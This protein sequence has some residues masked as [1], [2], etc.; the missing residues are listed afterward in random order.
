MVEETTSEL[1]KLC[2]WGADWRRCATQLTLRQLAGVSAS[3][4]YR[5]SGVMVM[6]YL[7]ASIRSLD[8]EYDFYGR[9]IDAHD[10]KWAIR[11]LLCLEGKGQS[12]PNRRFRAISVLKL[13][14]HTP[15]AWRRDPSPERDLLRILASTMV[16]RCALPLAA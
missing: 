15:E 11:L 8:G 7:I 5:Q 2:G 14:G 6:D 13:S 1:K 10:T 3:A 16:E 4:G 9:R 12:A